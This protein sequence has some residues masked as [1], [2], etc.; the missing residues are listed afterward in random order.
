[1]IGTRV[2]IDVAETDD[3][4]S[5]HI[6]SERIK[7]HLGFTPSHSI[8]HAVEDLEAAFNK[9]LVPDS[10]TNQK[11]YNVRVMQALSLS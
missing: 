8:D 10:L 2:A 11:Y 4:R 7:D 1:M 9:G 5:Y 6:S 3:L